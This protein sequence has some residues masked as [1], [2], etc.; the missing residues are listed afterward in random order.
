[1]HRLQN[2]FTRHFFHQA[3]KSFVSDFMRLIFGQFNASGYQYWGLTF[4]IFLFQGCGSHLYHFVEP[5]ETLY[6]I[7]WAYGHDYHEVASW[8]HIAPP[9]IIKQGQRLRVVAPAPV[10]T[11]QGSVI[12]NTNKTLTSSPSA[13]VVDKGSTGPADNQRVTVAIPDTDTPKMPA[14]LVWQWP[15]KGGK[16]I[17]MFD[18]ADPGK[19]GVDVAGQSGQAVYSAEAG[20]VVYSGGGLNRYG[21]LIIIKHNETYLS[22]Y[23][24]NKR[25]LVQ[26][27]EILKAGQEIAEMGNTGTNSVKLH[28]EIRRNGKPIDPLTLLPKR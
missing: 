9:Y 4:I 27:G 28:F 22:A 2:F 12:S 3:E 24:H 17:Q 13:L 5:G 15:I 19:Q 18:P 21:K 8:N 25:L 16:L 10:V 11:P 26:E 14:N 1:L 7:S 6:S 23:A 20:R